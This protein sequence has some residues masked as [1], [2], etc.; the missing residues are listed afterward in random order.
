MMSADNVKAPARRTAPGAGTGGTFRCA[1][2]STPSVWEFDPMLDKRYQ[3]TRLGRPIVDFLAWM[4]QGGGAPRTLDQYE[5]DLSVGALM[6]PLHGLPFEPDTFGIMQPTGPPHFGDSQMVHVTNRFRP[7]SRRVRVAAYKSFFKWAVGTRRAVL[8]PCDALRPIKRAPKRTFDIFNG[9]EILALCELPI[10]DGAL[11]EVLFGTGARKEEARN[12]RL[13]DWRQEA[14]VDAPYGTVKLDGKGDKERL[15]PI[16]QTL[17]RKLTEL[18]VLEGLNP[19][20]HLW[21]TKPGG[22]TIV[23]RDRL[24]GDGSFHRWWVRCLDDA[25][26]RYRNPHMSRHTFALRFLRGQPSRRGR[27]ETLQ[28]V[29]GHDSIQTTADNYGH[30]DMR[31]VALDM[32][33]IDTVI[34]S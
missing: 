19:A 5:R 24:V 9:A 20:D 15:V 25:G 12:L 18:Q 21:Y 22:G 7:A 2:H 11:M 4:E 16:T 10:R 27:L 30:L 14:D 28:L 33:L 34:H 1:Q 13:R 17:A 29:L 6:F 3:Q 26:I 23:A 31:D 8:N 32:G